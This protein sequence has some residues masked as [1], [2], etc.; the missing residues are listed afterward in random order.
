[1]V[2]VGS[3][4]LASEIVT[5]IHEAL[6]SIDVDFVSKDQVF[7]HVELLSL[8]AHAGAVSHVRCLREL[9]SLE[10]LGEGV[11]TTVSLLD[12]LDFDSVVSQEEVKSEVL[13]ATVI[14]VIL[15]EG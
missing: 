10:E 5:L 1:V 7:G 2:E 6:A 12:L 11:S 9:L 3:V 4:P 15:P 14:R 13:V 8:E